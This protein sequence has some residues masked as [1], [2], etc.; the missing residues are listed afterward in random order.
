MEVQL[1]YMSLIVYGENKNGNESDERLYSLV[2]NDTVNRVAHNTQTNEVSLVNGVETGYVPL[3]RCPKCGTLF[4]GPPTHNDVNYFYLL[5]DTV[6]RSDDLFTQ[7]YF[8]KFFE[9]IGFLGNGSNGSV[10]KV[11]HLLN[12]TSLGVFALKKITVGDDEGLLQRTLKEV[13]ML[14]QISTSSQHLVSYNHVWFEIDRINEFGPRVPCAFILEQYYPG[15]NLEDMVKEIKS[16]K[17]S[18]KEFKKTRQRRQGRYL[19]NREVWHIFRDITSGLVELHK[20]GI[21]HRDLKPS[22]ILLTSNYTKDTDELP[23]VVI[24]DFGESQFLG[25]RRAGTGFTGTL[26]YSAPEVYLHSQSSFTE[27]TDMFSMGMILYFLC[28]GDLPSSVLGASEWEALTADDLTNDKMDSLLQRTTGFRI[29]GREGLSERLT[30]VIRILTS[31]DPMRRLSSAE[32]LQRLET[33]ALETP[34]PMKPRWSGL[35]LLV[36]LIQIASLWFIR[37]SPRTIS[38]TLFFFTGISLIHAIEYKLVL[39]TITISVLL[40]SKY[41]F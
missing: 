30:E 1:S 17:W 9:T 25:E 34:E 2:I 35:W 31:R 23:T 33:M 14:A 8:A 36:T 27:K 21:I 39:I 26:E 16:P 10:F 40:L 38:N 22:N 7:G 18:L 13:K 4:S 32:L 5:E 28:F 15:G 11:E 20:H 29:N 19:T 41:S 6:D 24:G 12:G 3:S 37:S